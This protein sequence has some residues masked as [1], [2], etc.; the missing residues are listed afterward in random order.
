MRT[1]RQLLAEAK[2]AHN[3]PAYA[4][5][6][7]VM[8]CGVQGKGEG[9]RV[10]DADEGSAY[11]AL[12]DQYG[13]QSFGYSHPRIVAAVREQL[14]TGVLN[15]TKIMF[16]EVQIRLSERLAEATG[17]R[18]PYSY[19]ANGGGESIDNAL[20]LARAA[21]G[22]PGVISARGCFHGKT[23]ATLSASDRPEH[24][25]L[26][27]PFMEHFRQVDFGD[28]D[29]LA[30]ALDDTVAA[31]L[32]EPVQAEA[33]VIVPPPGYLQEVRRL[34]T[35]AGALLVLDEMQTAF[36]RCGTFFAHEQ[37]GITPD[38]VCVGKAFGGGVL[39]LSAVLGT[40]RVWEV[41][42]VLPSTFGSS[43][44][45]NPLS[46][47]VGI[48]A[49]EI[50]SDEAFLTT[51]KE[52]S[53]TID[54]RLSAAAARHPALIAEHRG[55]GM[56]HGLEFTDGATAGLVLGRL[57]EERVTS[58][59]SLY[60][61]S[62]L[63]VQPPMVISE[64]DLD[65]GLSVLESVLAEVD[66]HRQPS[67]PSGAP[68]AELS[69]VTRTVRLPYPAAQVLDM[70]ASRP[71][72]L[73]PF[74]ADPAAA[75]APGHAPE[76][77]GRL[78]GDAVVWADRAELLDDGVRLTAEPGWLWH[79]LERRVTVTPG[80]GGSLLEVR[81]AWNTDSGAY[82]DMLGG[83]IGFLAGERLAELITAL[84]AELDRQGHLETLERKSADT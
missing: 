83:R 18:L 25:A 39:P 82:E 26:L 28:V 19:L 29:Q 65:H 77:A 38:L 45:G 84:E 75:A 13:N 9:S 49:I 59:Y 80:D 73:D 37:F 40:E 50:A 20:K 1:R 64:E 21:T 54:A 11:L 78:G 53:L 43:L 71:R 32:L 76:F 15:S 31:V 67:A 33:G 69:P 51:V 44:G 23:F 8:G 66:G 4:K 7:F 14:D 42:R 60:Q 34:C 46:C 22:R 47:R 55:L 17:Q 24:R 63:R 56:M 2:A 10:L 5:M 30:A 74:A 81:V 72:L 3:H 27:G 58:T 61:T 12:F 16:E 57:L 52:R 70:L 68:T 36:G 48:E 35:E 6:A 41:L 62:V 79:T